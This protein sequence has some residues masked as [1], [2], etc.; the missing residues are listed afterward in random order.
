MNLLKLFRLYRWR[1]TL[2]VGQFI[3]VRKYKH[4]RISANFEMYFLNGYSLVR[5]SD[6]EYDRV[7][8]SQIYPS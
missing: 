1:K 6:D 3:N 7:K 8:T 4:L 5:Y 2:T